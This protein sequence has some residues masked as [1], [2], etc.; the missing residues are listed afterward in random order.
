MHKY[1]LKIEYDGSNFVGW[2]KQNNA[3]SVQQKLEEAM[4]LVQGCDIIVVGAGRTDTGVHARKMIAHFD[5]EHLKQPIND[6]IFK[7]NIT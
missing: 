5:V 3:T 6:L 1:K 4:S 7:P 2:Q